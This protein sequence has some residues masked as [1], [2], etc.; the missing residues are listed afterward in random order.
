MTIRTQSKT[1]TVPGPRPLPERGNGRRLRI[2][3][4]EQGVRDALRAIEGSH[5]ARMEAL[6]LGRNNR[7]EL[8]QVESPVRAGVVPVSRYA[9]RLRVKKV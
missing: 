2:E 9:S 8:Q 3:A 1:I 4:Y 5:G 7:A 6:L